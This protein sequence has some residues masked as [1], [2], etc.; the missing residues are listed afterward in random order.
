MQEMRIE[1]MRLAIEFCKDTNSD[2]EQMLIVAEKILR[3]LLSTKEIVD[4]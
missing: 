1:S 2:T 4:D 3:Y